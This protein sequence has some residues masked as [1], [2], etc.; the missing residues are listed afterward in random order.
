MY[1][2][3]IESVIAEYLKNPRAEYAVMIDGDW[4]SGKT[5]FLTHSLM[6]IMETIDIGKDK[7]RKYA[8][9]SLYG[10]KSVDEVSREI[11]FQCF[12]KKHKKK[13]ETADAVME[14]ASNILT[15]SL[16]AVNIDL[17]KI[18]ET[19][20]KID[21]NNWIICFDDLERCC[22]PINE[23][24]GYINR[25]VE[26]NNC[27]VI[28]LANEKEIGKITLNQRLEEKYQV[29]LS[30]RKLL[31]VNND[32]SDANNENGINIKKLQ[33]D[34]KALF[35]EDIL[36]KSIREKV[37][38]LTIKYEPQMDIAFDSII[39][40]YCDGTEFKQYIVN[41]KAKILGFFEEEECYNLRT[42]ISVFGSVKKV[43]DEMVYHDYNS[44]KYFDKIMDAFSK[45][46][47]L[48]TIFY[49]NGGKVRDL[50]L[51]T[52]IGYV[53]LGQSIFNHT[54]GFKFLEKYCMT[55]S[56][57]EQEFIN[58]VA[59]LRQEYDEEEK[60]IAKS[61]QGLAKAYSELACWWEKE[62]DVVRELV[63]LLREEIKQ[64][65][66]LFS[67]YQSI[68]GQ[69]MVLRH[70]G[71]DIGDMDELIGFMN[72]NIEKSEEVVDVERRSY[73]FEDSPELRRQYDEYVD[74]LKL[75]A[76]NKNQ[77]IKAGELS[78]YMSSENWAEELLDYCD[79]H[80]NEFIS[81]Y[82]F[83]DLLDMD[84]LLQKM[85]GASTK[86]MCLIKDIFKAVYR[87][88][89]INEFF[90]NDTE[91]IK[92]FKEAVEQMEITGI[93]KSIAKKALADYLDDIIK[94]LE[95]DINIYRI[96]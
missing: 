73:S 84:I 94:R 6:R 70:W 63:S 15:A 35:N 89:N 52:E 59:M 4:G 32:S 96:E 25:L 77:I 42:L 69:L 3:E 5:Y 88:S 40:D 31:F 11:V 47:I 14:T 74:R 27:K 55:L 37:I 72:D 92:R 1:S 46:I 38:G 51:T 80:Y 36:Y 12:G 9:V 60:R 28:V 17:S 61:K 91:E 21:I 20:A 56:F 33:N 67:N 41:N 71:H 19:L 62:D 78:Q 18:K 81:R 87:V 65:K 83:I 45:Y 24:L 8:Y 66:Y 86:E 49:K 76:G 48:F 16:G 39:A 93:N 34:T 7:R 30:G 29:V 26:H 82:G 50:N 79:K 2:N 53:H 85:N 10:A 58:V 43:Y 22:L 13:V 64:D 54:R 44:V 68:I 95:K 75:K 90:V 23:I 57:S